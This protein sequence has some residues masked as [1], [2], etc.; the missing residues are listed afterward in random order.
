MIGEQKPVWQE[1]GG[2]RLMHTRLLY[3]R[4]KLE[5]FSTLA[6]R[7]PCPFWASKTECA[8]N[9]FFGLLAGIV[10]VLPLVSVASTDIEIGFSPE[11]SALTLVIRTIDDAQRSVRLMGYVFTSPDVVK[12]LIDAKKRG[13][14]VQVIVDEKANRNNTSQAALNLLVNAG[15]PTRIISAY[16]ITHDKVIVADERTTE[17]GSFN[18]T[19]AATRSNSENVIVIRNNPEV[20]KTYLSHWQSRWE[21]GQDW[22]STY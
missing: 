17:T 13:V 16:K 2:S 12:S 8:M 15:I 9:K 21:K 18:Y 5:I 22:T 1:G 10:L 14:D 6:C 7:L 20:A 3:R 11:G 4:I 19:R